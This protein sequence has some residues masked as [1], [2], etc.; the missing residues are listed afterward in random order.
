MA[1][2]PGQ[3]SDVPPTSTPAWGVCSH[4]GGLARGLAG[5]RVCV[6][7]TRFSRHSL[8]PD[9]SDLTIATLAPWLK[10][11]VRNTPKF[12]QAVTGSLSG[13]ALRHAQKPVLEESSCNV[14]RDRPAPSSSTSSNRRQGFASPLRALDPGS[15]P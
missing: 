14:P 4:N 12:S 15:I 3:L 1:V 10:H 2:S 6:S 8:Y 7:I 13:I 9:I 5:L 11:G